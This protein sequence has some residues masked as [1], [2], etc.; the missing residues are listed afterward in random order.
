MSTIF[1]GFDVESMLNYLKKFCK[2]VELTTS[3]DCKGHWLLYV[4]DNNDVGN[5]YEGT[6]LRV[7]SKAFKS[8][9]KQAKEHREKAQ[10]EIERIIPNFKQAN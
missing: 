4:L 3:N 5:I 10:A 2:K 8:F 6:L 9:Y 1:L 7:T